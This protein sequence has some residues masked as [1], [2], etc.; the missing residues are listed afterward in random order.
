MKFIPRKESRAERK[1]KSSRSTEQGVAGHQA[2][3]EA[4]GSA[5]GWKREGNSAMWQELG[6][7]PDGKHVSAIKIDGHHPGVFTPGKG[8]VREKDK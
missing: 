8:N 4:L 6:K 3:M 5:T 2:A 1:S 7:Q